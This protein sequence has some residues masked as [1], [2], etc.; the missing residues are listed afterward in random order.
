MDDSA[1]E[2]LWAIAEARQVK[3]DPSHDFGH[4]RRVAYLAE[5]IAEAEGA[6]RDVVLAAALLHD[7][8]VYR[9]DDPQSH[10]ESDES[11]TAA[12]EILAALPGFPAE[13]I[14]AVQV[15]IRECSFSKALAASSPESAVLQDADLLES[16]GAIS[17]ARTF[18]SGGQMCRPFYDPADPFCRSGGPVFASGKVV[19][20]SLDL[21]YVRLLKAK[22]RIRSSYALKIAERREAFLRAFLEELEAELGEAGEAA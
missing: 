2:R 21:F 7:T 10:G 20:T 18:S 5:K 6:D 4:V 17:V 3:N 15:C 1:R 22:E 12:R 16:L 19:A 11:A 8:V 9:K 13:K 14:S